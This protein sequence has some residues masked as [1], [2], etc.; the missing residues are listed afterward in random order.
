GAD[1]NQKAR[2]KSSRN[3]SKDHCPREDSEKLQSS[4]AT[5]NRHSLPL[6]SRLL[7]HHRRKLTAVVESRMSAVTVCRP[8]YH[9]RSSN[10][11]CG[12]PASG[13]PTGFIARHTAAVPNGHAGGGTLRARRTPPPA[14]NGGGRAG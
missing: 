3:P 4:G 7:L 8:V 14:G 2:R 6:L 12:F 10:R 11:T 9:P 13:F 1:T 5:Y